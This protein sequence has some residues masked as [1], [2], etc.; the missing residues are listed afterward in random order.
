MLKKEA[1]KLML[2]PLQIK[3]LPMSCT[4]NLFWFLV[5]DLTNSTNLSESIL[6]PYALNFTIKRSQ[7]RHTKASERFVR[8]NQ[9]FL[10]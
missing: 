5:C 2:G 4:L 7:K 3:V 10:L 9:L 6:N 8:K 1:L